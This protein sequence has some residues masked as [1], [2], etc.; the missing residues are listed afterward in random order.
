MTFKHG[1]EAVKKEKDTLMLQ[2]SQEK[3]WLLQYW[4]IKD[5][6]WQAVVIDTQNLFLIRIDFKIHFFI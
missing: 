5:S 6:R 3:P 4:T 2:M 1:N